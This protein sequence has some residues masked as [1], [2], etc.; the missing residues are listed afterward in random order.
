MQTPL[1]CGQFVSAGDLVLSTIFFLSFLTN[2]LIVG[3]IFPFANITMY[4]YF[5]TNKAECQTIFENFKFLKKKSLTIVLLWE[6]YNCMKSKDIVR[7][8]N[9]LREYILEEYSDDSFERSRINLYKYKGLT[10]SIAWKPNVEP[11][12]NVQIMAFE[13]NFRIETGQKN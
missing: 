5:T 13:A 11:N 9:S 2:W 3:I 10:I 7:A 4:C 1:L 6:Y 12:F 8:E